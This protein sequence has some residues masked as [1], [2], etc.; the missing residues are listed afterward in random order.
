M[1]E[2]MYEKVYLKERQKVF[3]EIKSLLE[4]YENEQENN[5]NQENRNEQK[6]N[7]KIKQN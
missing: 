7:N 2:N 3:N 4:I 5:I 6:Q 1:K